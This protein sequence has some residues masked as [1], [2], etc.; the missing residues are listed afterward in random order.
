[1]P[2]ITGYTPLLKLPL[3]MQ[4]RKEE[5]SKAEAAAKQ[6]AADAE[7]S[8]SYRGTIRY[9][10]AQSMPHTSRTALSAAPLL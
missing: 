4:V 6:Q 2:R 5:E 7:L 3:L 8:T 10:H 9:K 1:M